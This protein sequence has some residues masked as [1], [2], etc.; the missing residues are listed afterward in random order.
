[1]TLNDNNLNTDNSSALSAASVTHHL[2]SRTVAKIPV[3]PKKRGTRITVKPSVPQSLVVPS[4]TP[5]LTQAQ[6]IPFGVP[7]GIGQ[8]SSSNTIVP[9]V[10]SG[11]TTPLVP[12]TVPVDQPQGDRSSHPSRSVGSCAGSLFASGNNSVIVQPFPTNSGDNSGSAQG[13]ITPPMSSQL[14]LTTTH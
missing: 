8:P 12:T 3:V 1:M 5:T 9:N 4:V 2:R 10:V 6:S 14:T 11:D 13:G 7:L